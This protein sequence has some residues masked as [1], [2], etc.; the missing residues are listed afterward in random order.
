MVDGPD[1]YA[2]C[3]NNPINCIDPLGLYWGQGIVDWWLYQSV[4][5]GP[6]GQPVSQW[7][8]NGPTE[9]G[10][11]F[12]PTDAAGG[13]IAC[14]ERLLYGAAV[15][16]T[17]IASGAILADF[18]PLVGWKGGEMTFTNPGSQTP[19]F[20]INPFGDWDSGNPYGRLPH[21][22]RRPGIGNHR[23]WEGGW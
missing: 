13:N 18:D 1:E 7:G 20:R 4:V 10:N 9:W 17:A 16:A 22:H 15:G 5:P 11:I 8:P 21:Y 6:Y 19:D 2:Y 23:P 14:A 12:E 3:G